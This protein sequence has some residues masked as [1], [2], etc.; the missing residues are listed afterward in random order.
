MAK[1]FVSGSISLV[2]LTRKMQ[3]KL[4]ELMRERAEIIVGDA[5]GIDNLVHLYCRLSDYPYVVIYYSTG[6][7]PRNNAGYP[8][9][10][11]PIMAGDTTGHVSKDIA[12]SNDCDRGVVF[13][14]GKSKGSG[15]NIKRLREQGK[16]VCVICSNG[17]VETFNQGGKH[18]EQR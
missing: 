17:Y 14:D 5:P 7:K 11:I 6:L 2:R 15:M 1:V 16:E 3:G 4:D 13:W 18:N 8:S 10:H 12:M 9:V